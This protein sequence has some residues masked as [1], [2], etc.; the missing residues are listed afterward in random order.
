MDIIDR[1]KQIP[2]ILPALIIG[3]TIHEFAHAFVADKLGDKTP[4]FQGRLSLNPAAHIDPMGLIMIILVG[5][6]WAKP[7][8]TNPYAYKNY[9]MDDLKVSIA[10]PISNLIVAVIFTPI[11]FLYIFY[12]A[13]VIPNEKLAMV[14]LLMINAIVKYNIMLFIF[15]LIPIPPLDG[16][17][18]LEDLFPSKFA[19]FK[20]KYGQYQLFILILFMVTP[21]FKYIVLVPAEKIY[22]LLISIGNLLI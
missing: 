5:F 21:L 16:F 15:N 3:F 11:L 18:I 6:G 14:L 4:R 10:G 20:Y 1:L 12:I 22:S 2:I 17:H 7:V 19:E 8:Q 9:R 13:P